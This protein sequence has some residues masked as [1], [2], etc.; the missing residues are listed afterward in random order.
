VFRPVFEQPDYRLREV[1]RICLCVLP[2]F[3]QL[4]NATVSL[5]DSEQKMLFGVR[6][7]GCWRPVEERI[8]VLAH[9]PE[10]W[11]AD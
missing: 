11:R 5:R 1:F 3:C 8:E 10:C 7:V 9:Q 2:K 4:I 6:P